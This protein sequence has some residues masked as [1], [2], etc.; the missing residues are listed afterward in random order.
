MLKSW[1]VLKNRRIKKLRGLLLR[2]FYL[3]GDYNLFHTYKHIGIFP[4]ETKTFTHYSEFKL[5]V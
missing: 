4:P 2:S 3:L 1:Q 5:F